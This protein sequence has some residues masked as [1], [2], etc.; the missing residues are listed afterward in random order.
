MPISVDGQVGGKLP[1][2]EAIKQ[3]RINQNVFSAQY[4]GPFGGGIEIFTSS[5]MSK[6]TGTLGLSFADSRINASDA[7][8]GRRLPAQQKSV[9]FSLSG[10]LGKRGTIFMF[11]SRGQNDNRVAINAR[12]LD[13]AIDVF[14]R[15][16]QQS[17]QYRQSGRAD[18]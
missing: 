2:K 8:I 17:V 9:S 16:N 1:P 12:T 13:S 10:P 14:W 3:I 15:P 5:N 6:F 4:E 18:R 11:G 7:F